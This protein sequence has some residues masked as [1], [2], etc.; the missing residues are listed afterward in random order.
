MVRFRFSGLHVS[1]F[2]TRLSLC[3]GKISSALSVH[4][5]ENGNPPLRSQVYTTPGVPSVP[6]AKCQLAMSWVAL[7]T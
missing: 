6:S 3:G 1:R 4:G 2:F 7:S 5:G